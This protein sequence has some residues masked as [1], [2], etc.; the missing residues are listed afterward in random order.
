MLLFLHKCIHHLPDI[1]T[2]YF[3]QNSLVHSYN[4]KDKSGLHLSAIQMTIDKRIL[5]H[6]GSVL[7]NSL[8]DFMKFHYNPLHSLKVR[9]KNLSISRYA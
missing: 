5:I 2:L 3:T 4:T 9:L 1:F 7:C 8:P 6:K